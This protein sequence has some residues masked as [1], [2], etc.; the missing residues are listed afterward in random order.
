MKD[1]P[2]KKNI[3]M[4]ENLNHLP[5]GTAISLVNTPF[6]LFVLIEVTPEHRYSITI[7]KKG[8]S[9]ILLIWNELVK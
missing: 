9:R 5:Q 2:G 7:E 8:E 1:N 4:L 3:A 6:A